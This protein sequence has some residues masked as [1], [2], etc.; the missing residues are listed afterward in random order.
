MK[1]EMFPFEQDSKKYD[2]MLIDVDWR[3]NII[4]NMFDRIDVNI[5]CV[6]IV[7][8]SSAHKISDDIRIYSPKSI[9]SEWLD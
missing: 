2:K 6:G 3:R 8:I 7:D 1:R 4:K 5:D 9:F